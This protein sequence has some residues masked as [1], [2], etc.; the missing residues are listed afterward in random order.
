MIF[1]PHTVAWGFEVDNLTGTPDAAL[2]SAST[3][4]SG[5]SNADG[6]AVTLLSGLAQ[7]VQYIAVAISGMGVT[8]GENNS[9]LLDILT[10]P[11]GGTSW[12]VLINDLICGGDLTASAGRDQIG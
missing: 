11:A 2:F 8:T 10:D 7:D 5:A 6:T 9:C 4:G 12:G 3:C 1:A